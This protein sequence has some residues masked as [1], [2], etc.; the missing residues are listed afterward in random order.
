MRKRQAELKAL[1]KD[2]KLAGDQVGD[3]MGIEGAWRLRGDTGLKLL[4][5]EEQDIR[6]N[7]KLAQ[8]I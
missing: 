3:P 6:Y 2:P 4:T 1:G 8:A 5:P 7:Q